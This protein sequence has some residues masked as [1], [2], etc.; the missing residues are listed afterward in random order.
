MKV[1]VFSDVQGNLPAMTTVVEDIRR[2]DPELVILNGDLVNRGPCSLDCLT[3]FDDLRRTRNWLPVG[4]NHEDFV[5]YC[6][7]HPRPPGAAGEL[8]RFT[9]WTVTQLGAAVDLLAGWPDHLTFADPAGH[10]WVHVTHGTLLGNRDG[11]TAAKPDAHLQDRLPE[12]LA[13]YITAHTHQALERWLGGLPILNIGSV[14]SPFDGDVRASYARLEYRAGRWHWQIRRLAYDRTAA[15]CDFFDS[16]FV[17]QGGPL[18][19]LIFEEWRLATMLMAHW[20]RRYRQAVLAG[21]IGL[22]KAVDDFL[23]ALR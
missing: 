4:G 21:H 8:R 12:G 11:V 6:Q 23:T 2:W 22:E 9:D 1:A 17:D 3:W 14:G 18:A 10:A 5:R 7:T 13:L 19:R 16:G 20:N 15:E